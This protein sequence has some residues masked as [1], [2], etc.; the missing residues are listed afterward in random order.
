MNR[1][2]LATPSS[3]E[4]IVVIGASLLALMLIEIGLLAARVN[5]Y[6]PHGMCF[7]WQPE[8]I[9]FVVSSDLVIAL[10]YYS[11][12][13]ILVRYV[14]RQ[15]GH[16]FNRLLLCF[17]GFIVL[18]GT[19]HLMAIVTIWHPY[20]WQ[21]AGIK[22]ATAVFSI[23]VAVILYRIERRAAT[24]PEVE[25]IQKAN[26]DLLQ[27]IERLRASYPEARELDEE[28][29][30]ADTISEASHLL[31]EYA[32]LVAALKGRELVGESE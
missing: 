1:W 7:L 9:G 13:A 3:K 32:R 14:R 4:S 11:M 26:R 21:E 6:M 20:Y 22:A 17:A 24:L 12:P 16:S 25:R 5:D 8:L 15:R 27:R 10:A 30:A 23:T 18:C 29:K 31:T 2:K 19:T 28:L